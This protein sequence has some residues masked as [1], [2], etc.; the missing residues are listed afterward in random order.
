MGDYA[1]ADELIQHA[2]KELEECQHKIADLEKDLAHRTKTLQ[3]ETQREQSIRLAIS[4]LKAHAPKSWCRHC[5]KDCPEPD[6]HKMHCK[7]YNR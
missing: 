1:Y 2:E 5:K 3:E 6:D 4:Q 7:E